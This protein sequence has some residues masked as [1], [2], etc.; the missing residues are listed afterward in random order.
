[1]DLSPGGGAGERLLIAGHVLLIDEAQTLA[2]EEKHTVQTARRVWDC[3]VVLAKF[4]EKKVPRFCSCFIAVFEY[5]LSLF[6]L[7]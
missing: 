1:L 3:A 7:D 6:F 5:H 4:L 2:E